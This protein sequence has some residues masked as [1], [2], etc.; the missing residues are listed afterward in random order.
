MHSLVY[1]A[2]RFSSSSLRGMSASE[3]CGVYKWEWLSGRPYPRL[4]SV[5]PITQNVSFRYHIWYCAL[6]GACASPR[7]P[8]PPRQVPLV[9]DS[10]CIELHDDNVKMTTPIHTVSR[11]TDATRLPPIL[12]VKTFY[13]NTNLCSCLIY[14]DNESESCYLGIFPLSCLLHRFQFRA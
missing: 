2:Q 5:R 1:A 7:T 11:V 9:A 6:H 13:C 12:V 3:A 10:E 14:I 8:H 4:L